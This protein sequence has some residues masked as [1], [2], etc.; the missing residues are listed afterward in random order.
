MTGDGWLN[1]YFE[2]QLN[3]QAADGFF[4]QLQANGSYDDVIAAMLDSPQYYNAQA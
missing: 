1:L 2:G 4:N 3:A